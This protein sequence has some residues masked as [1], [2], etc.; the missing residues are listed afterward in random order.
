MIKNKEKMYV[1]G[2]LLGLAVLVAPY[3]YTILYA[4]PSSDDF[5]MAI[6]VDK[7]NLFG[8]AVRVA[9]EYYFKWAG[10]WISIFL[11]ILFN[12]LLLFGA[13]SSLYGVEMVIHF[14]LYA[15]VIG[16]MI[17]NIFYYVVQIKDMKM[18]LGVYLIVLMSI[19]NMD[20]WTE[21]FYWFVGA[22]YLHGMLFGM[23]SIAL[24]VKYRA[25]GG[26]F[27]GFLLSV[28]GFFGCSYFM[29]AVLPATVYLI[30]LVVDLIKDR[31]IYWKKD[32][33]FFFYCAGFLSAL[34]APGNF[35]RLGSETGE[36]GLHLF[37]T[38]LDTLVL[39]LDTTFDLIKNP[40]VLIAMLVLVLIG[41]VIFKEMK[42]KFQYPLL[43]FVLTILCLYIT[44]FPMALGY[45]GTSYLP[46][47]VRFIF[48]TYAVL[49]YA[50]SFLYLG[51]FVY[52]KKGEFITKKNLITAVAALAVFGYVCIMPTKYYEE[53]PYAKTVSQ[54]RNVKIVNSEW[55][56]LLRYIE[57]TEEKELYLSR[58]KINTTII[59]APGLTADE[60]YV[61]N[62]KIAEYFGKDYI[63]LEQW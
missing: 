3:I 63:K 28:I 15:V 7:T 36:T 31:K 23:S 26:I 41:A 4:V 43:P 57:D 5:V 61:V 14:C 2:L 47:R 12:P 9:N 19:L 29:L 54:I 8:E 55:M 51:G 50:A 13:T 17:R 35:S 60:N 37:R 30:Y 44:Y 48:C 42:F 32:I 10:D 45:G 25:K 33:P 16:W 20:V 22:T 56:Y 21:I 49:M 58:S 38:A 62:Q 40:L 6:G 46:N 18:I 27:T 52:R 39:W 34:V 59:K 24:L 1:L 11:Q 53:L